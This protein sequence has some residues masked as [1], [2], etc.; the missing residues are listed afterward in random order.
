MIDPNAPA[1][2]VVV[3]RLRA[4]IGRRQD[5]RPGSRAHWSNECEIRVLQRSL[6]TVDGDG[7]LATIGREPD[8]GTP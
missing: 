5:L 3:D 8:A 1:P 4:A 2:T 7:R 6:S